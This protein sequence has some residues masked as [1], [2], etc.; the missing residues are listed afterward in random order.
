MGAAVWG[1]GSVGGGSSSSSNTRGRG[2]SLLLSDTHAGLSV[3]LRLRFFVAGWLFSQS[4]TESG[5]LDNGKEENQLGILIRQA[6]EWTD[7]RLRFTGVTVIIRR[8]ELC[9]GEKG[10]SVWLGKGEHE[11]CCKT[12]VL[13]LVFAYYLRSVTAFTMS[14]LLINGNPTNFLYIT[15]IFYMCINCK[16]KNPNVVIKNL[17]LPCFITLHKLCKKKHFKNQ[18]PTP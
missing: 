6:A 1:C 13:F 15:N 17:W 3:T 18:T 2:T 12:N 11:C 9:L 14:P 10:F 5:S 7:G 8:D 4:V 16:V